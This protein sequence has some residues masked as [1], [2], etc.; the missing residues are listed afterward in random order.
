MSDDPLSGAVIPVDPWEAG[1]LEPVWAHENQIQ[2]LRPRA[3][4][5]T[6]SEERAFCGSD[7]WDRAHMPKGSCGDGVVIRD[8]TRTKAFVG[9]GVD[10]APHRGARR[11]EAEYC[12]QDDH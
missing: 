8:Q 2:R 7:A 6:L 10:L 9:P 4:E 1:D 11:R 5:R 3:D 12:R